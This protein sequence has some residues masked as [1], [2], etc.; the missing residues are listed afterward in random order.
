MSW[1]AIVLV[2]LTMI[3]VFAVIG[4]AYLVPGL[5]GGGVVRKSRGQPPLR[6]IAMEGV[7]GQ[8]F[9]AADATAFAPARFRR[10]SLEI[11]RVVIHRPDDLANILRAARTFDPSTA[12]APAAM[13]I[14]D[15][16]FGSSVGVSLTARGAAGDGTIQRRTWTGE[17]VDMSFVLDTDSDAKHVTIDARVFIDDAQ[18]GKISFLRPITPKV[19][20]LESLRCERMRYCRR[21]FLSYSSRDREVVSVIAASYQRAGVQLFWD[22]AS[23]KSGEEWSPLLRREIDNSDLYHLCW[24]KSAATS[25]WVEKEAQYALTRRRQ[26]NGKCPDVTVQMLDGP[27]WAPHPPALDSINFDDFVRAAIVGYA[28]G[29]Y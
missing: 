7:H 27:P 1:N 13:K 19:S 22:R 11:V 25:Q 15:V 12:T 9:A 24:S 14:G 4:L 6:N 23:L 5:V 28:R 10:G 21:V 18:I 17:S 3:S 20:A 16:A 2:V 26:T 8:R 29:S